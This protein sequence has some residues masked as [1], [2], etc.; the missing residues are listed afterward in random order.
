MYLGKEV[1]HSCWVISQRLCAKFFWGQKP[2]LGWIIN[3]CVKTT[4]LNSGRKSG[5]GD[6]NMDGL[7]TSISKPTS[8]HV[9]IEKMKSVIFPLVFGCKTPRLTDFK[10]RMLF[11][12]HY[13]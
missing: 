3:N 12:S 2:M 7:C 5:H 4:R 13:A 6:D 8:K 1:S 11:L 10:Q 9:M